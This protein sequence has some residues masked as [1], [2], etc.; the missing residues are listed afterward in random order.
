LAGHRRLSCA[1]RPPYSSHSHQL[2]RHENHVVCGGGTAAQH[3]QQ[4]TN[5]AKNGPAAAPFIDPPRFPLW[6][7][8]RPGFLAPGARREYAAMSFVRNVFRDRPAGA[9]SIHPF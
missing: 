7:P 8:E 6:I 4:I 5:A 2:L 1:T 9:S 3:T